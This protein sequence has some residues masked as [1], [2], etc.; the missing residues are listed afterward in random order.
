MDGWLSLADAARALSD[1]GDRISRP[2]LSQYLNTHPEVPR[3]SEGPGLPVYVDFAA[4]RLSRQTRRGRGPNSSASAELVSFSSAPANELAA[5]PLQ[6]LPAPEGNLDPLA[7]R[8]AKAD[9]ERAESE[10]RR[11]AVLAAEAEGRSIR[12]E[13]AVSAFRA[14]GVALA[15]TLEE[16]R[17]SAIEALASPLAA[18]AADL[19]MR[20]YEREV[21]AAFAA[22]LMDIAASADPQA[23]AAQ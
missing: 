22:S 19:A 21:R 15:R 2:G 6:K 12:K 1:S 20:A 16:K 14:A 23:M 4:L 11:A 13:V 7:Q 5:Q 18:R 17:A 9:T 3:R 10:A 8:K